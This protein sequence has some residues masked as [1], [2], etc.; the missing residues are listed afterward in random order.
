MMTIQI[1]EWLLLIFAGLMLINV[2]LDL[3]KIY[4]QKK[5]NE[6]NIRI[7]AQNNAVKILNG[8]E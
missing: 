2:F 7:A 4:L 3:W 8:G 1:P 5:T 6:L